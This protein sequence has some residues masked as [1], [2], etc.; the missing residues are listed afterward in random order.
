MILE[1]RDGAIWE[2]VRTI[3]QGLVWR[4]VLTKEQLEEAIEEARGGVL[5]EMPD[6]YSVGLEDA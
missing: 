6:H 3:E 1:L 2:C 4:P 5:Y